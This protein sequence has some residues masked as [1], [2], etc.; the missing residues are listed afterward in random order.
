MFAD[1]FFNDLASAWERSQD[2]FWPQARLFLALT[3]R[4]LGLALLVGL[5]LGVLLTRVRRVAEFVTAVIALVQTVPALVLFAL[6]ISLLGLGQ[7]PALAAAVVYSLL[8]LVLNTYVGITQVSPAVRDAARGMGMTALQ[9]L[10]HVELPLAFPVILA[11]VRTAAIAASGMIV[12][13]SVIGAGGLGDFIYNGINRDDSGL[14]WLGTIPVLILT[15][16]L[17]VGLGSLERLARKKSALG[18]SLGGGLIV[19][20]AA[21]AVYGLVEPAFTPRTSDLRVGARDFTEGQ[22]LAEI[23][24][25]ELEA[26]TGLRV[27]IVTNLA[28]SVSLKSLKTGDIDLYPEYTGN[29]LTNKDGLNLPVPADRATIT[30]LVRAEMAARYKIAV[31]DEFGLNNTYA[32]CVT[33]ATAE[34]YDLHTIGDLRRTPQLRVV[35]DLSFLTRPDGWPGLVAKYDLHFVK[36]PQQV[37]PNLLYRALEQK[38]ADLVIG[39]ATDWQIQAQDLVVLEDD[40]GY[41]PNYHAVPLVREATIK[42]H[43]EIVAA[44]NR[45]GGRIG[46]RTMRQMNYQVAVEKRSEAEVARAFLQG[47]GLLE[48]VK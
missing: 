39:F 30:P 24:K 5:P 8:P 26:E 6:M 17:F 48:K 1:G 3:L 38:E 22:I 32:P 37:G 27:E 18:M 16:A 11:G 2:T 10:W 21:Y 36:P 28:T 12:F 46:D 33:R 44:L 35:V 40:R 42:R 15:F 4:A 43:P 23:V 9:I 19:L 34:R 47:Q 25:Q 29:L 14:I 7:R 13:A 31:L 41:F 20:L 45:L